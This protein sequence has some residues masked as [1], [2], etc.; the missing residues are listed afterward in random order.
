MEQTREIKVTAFQPTLPARGAT[1]SKES[2]RK[3]MRISTHAPRTGSDCIPTEEMTDP[4]GISTHAPRTGSD[5]AASRIL[6][7]AQNFNPRSPHG[8][9]PRRCADYRVVFRISTHAPRTG[10]DVSAATADAVKRTFQPT[11]PA[12]GATQA[13]FFVGR[14]DYDFNPR[15]PH[16]ERHLDFARLLQ[17]L[18]FQ[19]TLPARGATQY[20]PACGGQRHD[21]NPRSPHGE[22]PLRLATLATPFNFNPRSPHGERRTWSPKE[23]K[24]RN[25][26][27]RSPHGERQKQTKKA[28]GWG[29][30]STHAPRTGSD[31]SKRGFVP[32][33][34]HFNP[35]SPHGERRFPSR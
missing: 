16:G 13:S 10:S 34:A 23:N 9:R 26:N 8:E 17:N 29:K 12:R 28:N 31:C 32:E 7:G 33:D 5:Q 25:F 21:F 18:R 22:R 35:R 11:L 4:D 24:V 6:L 20:Q 15:S 14:G 19:P 30:I 2:A 1:I 3:F 27:P